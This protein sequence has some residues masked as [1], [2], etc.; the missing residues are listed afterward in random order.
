MPA[1][2]QRGMILLGVLV[3][4]AILALI[5][6][7][8]GEQLQQKIQ[9]EHEKQLLFVGDQIR[10]ALVAYQK[11]GLNGAFYPQ[12]LADLVND[13]RSP[14]PRHFL[15]Q[16]YIDPMTGR[17]NWALLKGA[18]GRI[19]GVYSQSPLKPLKQDGFADPYGGFANQQRFTGWLFLADGA[20]PVNLP[21]GQK[22]PTGMNASAPVA[23]Q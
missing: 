23:P 16:L 10:N 6:L 17:A 21:T 22:L 7:R 13:T 18:D 14:A 9:R 4:V 2:K 11:G 19:V 8:A 1:G 15:R 20:T 5:M 3:M 12:T